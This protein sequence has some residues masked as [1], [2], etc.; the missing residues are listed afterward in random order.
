MLLTEIKVDSTMRSIPVVVLTA[1]ASDEDL[2]LCYEKGARYYLVK[3]VGL[4]HFIL[5][6]KATEA[7]LLE[8]GGP[9][10]DHHREELSLLKISSALSSPGFRVCG[11]SAPQFS[12]PNDSGPMSSGSPDDSLE[13]AGVRGLRANLCNLRLRGFGSF[14]LSKLTDGRKRRIEQTRFLRSALNLDFTEGTTMKV[15]TNV[16]AGGCVQHP[17]RPH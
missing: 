12:D 15:R 3:P 8:T 14:S 5:T 13:P 2:R 10:A 16:K 7:F 1:S 9:A 11:Y 17:C 4:E 6:A